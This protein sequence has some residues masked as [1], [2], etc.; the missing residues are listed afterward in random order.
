MDKVCFKCGKIKSIDEF[1][2]HP[3]MKDGHF[4]K[5]KECAKKDVLDKYNDNIKNPDFVEKERERGREK[6]KR[7]GYAS[8][9]SKNYKTKSCVYKGLSRSL[10]SRGFDLK[11]KE[12][13]HWDYD[14]LKSGFI[15]SRRAHK[16]IHKYLKLDN[17]NR[18]FFYG[19]NLL[20][21]KEK[22]RIFMD[23]IFEINNVDYK[24]VEFD[25]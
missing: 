14:C 9:H 24:Y 1:Y 20:D 4:N 15:L 8:K 3:Q 21:T 10:R 22:H 19:E 25:L 2:K 6:Y 11:Y 13:H 23:K 17:E 16:L 12:A 18:F 5:C 7:L